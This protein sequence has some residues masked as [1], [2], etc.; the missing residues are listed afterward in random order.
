[1]WQT[2]ASAVGMQGARRLYQ[3]FLQPFLAQHEEWVDARLA[4]VQGLLVS[5]GIL[6]PLPPPFFP[7]RHRSC[8]CS[9]SSTKTGLMSAW[10]L[11]RAFWSAGE[12]SRTPPPPPPQHIFDNFHYSSACSRS[13]IRSGL[14][15]TWRPCKDFWSACY[16]ITPH[17]HTT[18]KVLRKLCIADK[19]DMEGQKHE[20]S[21]CH[22]T[23]AV[24]C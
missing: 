13:C 20:S 23:T 8:S 18:H 9:R 10:Q 15:P 11:F 3:Q 22:V 1:M 16:P 21:G 4:T 17:P 6:P 19:L 24:L 5:L 12:S 7:P 14:M 2:H